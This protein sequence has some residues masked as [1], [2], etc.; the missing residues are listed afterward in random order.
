MGIKPLD[1]PQTPVIETCTFANAAAAAAATT[2]TTHFTN[3][4]QHPSNSGAAINPNLGA[5][6]SAVGNSFAGQ[7]ILPVSDIG[8]PQCMNGIA[9]GISTSAYQSTAESTASGELNAPSFGS[10]I[11]GQSLLLNQQQQ[12]VL[13]RNPV[14]REV[15]ELRYDGMYLI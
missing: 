12:H 2:S 15:G 5:A 7:S 6:T 14:D 1:S 4:Q 3:R 8:G 13:V 11:G 10:S 9:A